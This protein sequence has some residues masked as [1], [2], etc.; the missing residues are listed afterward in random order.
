MN[1]FFVFPCIDQT[2]DEESYQ[3][4]V[5]SLASVSNM[6]FVLFFPIAKDYA[7]LINFV[8]KDNKETKAN[9]QMLGIYQ[10]MLD[11]WKA[12]DRYLSG[13]VMDIKY[14]EKTDE[15]I[16]ASFFIIC[17]SM[18]N[19]DTVL[20]VTFVH[21][22][23]IA[24]MER[25]E[26]LVTNEL[27]Q[28]L[29]PAPDEDEDEIQDKPDHEDVQTKFPVDKQILDIARDIM[30]GKKKNSINEKEPEN[31]PKKPIKPIH[32]GRPKKDQK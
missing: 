17:D 8:L 29:L 10:T 6:A 21:A 3:G 26:V 30:S 31:E 15:E 12:G 27:L 14:S 7:D 24:A 4:T 5:V 2:D 20:N 22:V 19:V 25:K 32:K 9:L 13:I 18:G 28:K 23:M 1:K 11:S 16:I